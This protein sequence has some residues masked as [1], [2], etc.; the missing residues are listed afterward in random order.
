ML[1]VK[2]DENTSFDRV[3]FNSIDTTGN[4][5]GNF[6]IIT[7]IWDMNGS[8]DGDTTVTDPNDPYTWV[9]H[10]QIV[11]LLEIRDPCDVND[12]S[13]VPYHTF[14]PTLASASDTTIS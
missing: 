13:G 1:K 9:L 4:M 14:S 10:D 12:I 7:N 3:K 8:W 11:E 5:L 6:G 2:Q